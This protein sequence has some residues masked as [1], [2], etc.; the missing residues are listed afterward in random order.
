MSGPLCV[1]AGVGVFGLAGLMVLIAWAAV[2]VVWW[3][4]LVPDWGVPPGRAWSAG[5]LGGLLYRLLRP[6]PV[7]GTP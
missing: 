4:A 3:L 6:L 5:G 7:R 2:G 1:L